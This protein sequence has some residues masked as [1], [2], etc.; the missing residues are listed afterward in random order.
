MRSLTKLPSALKSPGLPKSVVSPFNSFAIII[1]FI[2]LGDALMAYTVPIYLD[3]V[4]HNTFLMGLVMATSSATGLLFDFLVSKKFRTKN[5]KYFMHT[6]F[7]FAILFP[8]ALLFLPPHLVFIVI[9]MAF[10]GIYFETKIY[11]EF[12]FIDHHVP[13]DEY[14]KSWGLVSVLNSSAYFFGSLVATLIISYSLKFTFAT[15]LILFGL[16]YLIFSLLAIKKE[17]AK[18]DSL[19]ESHGI[20]NLSFRQT[21]RVWKTLLGKIWPLWVFN[22]VITLVDAAFWTVGIIFSEQMRGIH[23]AG[24]LIIT[25]YMFPP[26][27][28]GF[29]LPKITANIGKKKTAFISALFAAVFVLLFGLASDVYLLILLVFSG[30]VF[31]SIAN[32]ALYAV[33]EDYVSRLGKFNNDMIGLEQTASSVGY[34]IGP[35]LAGGIAA[36]AGVQHTFVFTGAL[37]L[38]TSL[39]CLLVVPRKIRMP[40]KELAETIY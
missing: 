2:T 3:G 37:L 21:F 16:T 19:E 35:L 22:F 4:L 23:P 14:S 18:S 17:S 10:W 9:A 15:A 29:F 12:H 11:A 34:V 36:T 31:L 25:A 28:M 1:M 6:T 8:M 20:T 13:K 30:S 7:I 5:Y 32:P 40:Q 38:V 26:I 33:Y 39:V 24:G 27:F